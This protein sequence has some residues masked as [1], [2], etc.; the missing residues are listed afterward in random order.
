MNKKYPK[1]PNSL[2]IAETSKRYFISSLPEDWVAETPENDYGIDLR[3]DI[4]KN[5]QA[6][7]LELL[8]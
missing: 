7:G 8:V 5:N 6:T 2:Y 3:V 4:F 1:R